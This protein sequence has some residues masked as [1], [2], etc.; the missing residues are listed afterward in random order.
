[1]QVLHLVSFICRCYYADKF[2]SGLDRWLWKVLDGCSSTA[3]YDHNQQSGKFTAIA[4][5]AVRCRFANL[6]SHIDSHTDLA[7]ALHYAGEEVTWR[8]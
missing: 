1:M 7:T 3:E 4:K 8:L 5:L 2:I 6:S